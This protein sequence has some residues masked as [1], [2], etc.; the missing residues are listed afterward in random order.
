VQAAREVL[1]RLRARV[2][3]ISAAD[4][5][6]EALRETGYLATLMALPHGERRVANIEKFIEQARALASMTL[7]ELVERIGQMQFR[8]TRE[9]EATVEESGAVRLMTVHKSKGLEFPIVWLVDTT[10]KGK[11]SRDFVATHVDYGIAVRIGADHLDTDDDKLKASSFAMLQQIEQQMDRAEK[12]RLLYVAATRARDHLM[13]SG[14][15]GTSNVKGDH[16]LGR[17]LSS[18][19]VDDESRP[20]AFDYPGGDVAIYWHDADAMLLTYPAA[21]SA[22]API[23][24]QPATVHHP[25]GELLS[26]KDQS[27][28]KLFP[29]I[30][31][32]A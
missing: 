28:D 3:R 26:S 29:L 24:R 4:L 7:M 15:P 12:K 2:G 23:N 27:D 17:I 20:A 8:E 22:T 6:I 1:T 5:I 32:L 10:Y 21:V 13:I 9:G 30:G 31:P 11:S 14:A 19:E 18:L 25:D 16:W